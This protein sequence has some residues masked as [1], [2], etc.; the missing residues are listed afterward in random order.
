VP[1][2]GEIIFSAVTFS[3]GSFMSLAL[4]RPDAD[5]SRSVL[6]VS[7]IG[8]SALLIPLALSDTVPVTSTLWF[9]CWVKDTLESDVLSRNDEPVAREA[10]ALR[11]MLVSTNC[12]DAPGEVGAAETGEA[13]LPDPEPLPLAGAIVRLS[14]VFRQP[15]TVVAVLAMSD[16]GDDSR[17]A[18]VW[19]VGLGVVGLGVVGGGLVGLGV[20]GSVVGSGGRCAGCV[21]GVCWVGG[22]SV[23]G[24]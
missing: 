21:G 1:H 2:V 4:T 18:G 20:V 24:C 12:D 10:A 6:G 22:G 8:L 23:G 5:A 11:S 9:R 14:H 15:V 17:V 3:V 7:V 16:I 19:L 13:A